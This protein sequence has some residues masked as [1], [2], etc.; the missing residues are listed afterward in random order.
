MNILNKL[1]TLLRINHKV[2]QGEVQE[3]LSLQPTDEDK[4]QGKAA[5]VLAVAALAACG[6][7]IGALGQPVLEKVFTYVIRDL[8]DGAETPDK[9]IIGRIIK[10]VKAEK[11]I[12]RTTKDSLYE[13]LN[14]E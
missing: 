6:V 13:N 5:A 4:A 2:I 1:K 9:L 12:N 3:V 11:E 14:K 10:E 8:K 7:P